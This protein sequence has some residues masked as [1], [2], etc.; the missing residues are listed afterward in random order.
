MK[1]N[2]LAIGTAQFGLDYGIANRSGKVSLQEIERILQ[3]SEDCGINTLDTA[4]AYGNSEARLGVLG[5]RD[6]KV[7]SKLP[8]VPSSCKYV[9]DWVNSS[10]EGSLKRLKVD[11]LDGLLLHRPDDLNGKFGDQLYASLETLRNTGM[12]KKIG[13]SIYSPNELE[14]FDHF[15]ELNIIQAP[16]NLLDR[17]LM[18]VWNNFK[19]SANDMYIHTRSTFLQG[20]LLMSP[21]E[22]PEKFGRWNELWSQYD[23]FITASGLSRLEVCINYVLSMKEINNIVIGVDTLEQLKEICVAALADTNDFPSDLITNDI[24][25]LMPSRWP[26]FN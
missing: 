12:V 2:R 1:L 3:Y 18:E 14:L 24:D 8:S 10:V 23:D 16:F 22:R 5:V 19:S 11:F 26:T 6:W 13:L 15:S 20:L 7:I 25:L 21:E 17:R 4:I 9:D